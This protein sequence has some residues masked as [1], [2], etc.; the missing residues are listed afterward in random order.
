MLWVSIV[1]ALLLAQVDGVFAMPYSEGWLAI[2]VG[3]ALGRWAEPV[4][5]GG[6]QPSLFR[7]FAVLTAGV[8]G[9]VLLF[10][11]PSLQQAMQNFY[12]S[13][14]IG[15]PPRLWSQGWIPKSEL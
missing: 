3:M 6:Y 12:E 8:I 1:A 13:N 4:A 2:L 15:S 10:D 14:Q 9:W 7:L 11:V 5:A